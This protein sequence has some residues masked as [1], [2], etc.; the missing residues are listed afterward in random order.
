MAWPFHQ[1]LAEVIRSKSEL[2]SCC[3]QAKKNG[4]VITK[5]IIK[6]Y[7]KLENKQEEQENNPFARRK[8]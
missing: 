4:F 3:L 6:R 2:A 8:A 7:A 5:I 1:H